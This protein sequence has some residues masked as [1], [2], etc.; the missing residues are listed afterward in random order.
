MATEYTWID[1]FISILLGAC[2]SLLFRRTCQNGKCVV[3]KGPD[4]KIVQ[5]NTYYNDGSCY[6]LFPQ[7]SKC[8]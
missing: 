1:I 7:E 3:I 5:S 2:I 6:K 8:E 4:P